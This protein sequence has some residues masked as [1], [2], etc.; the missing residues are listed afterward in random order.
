MGRSYCDHCKKKIAAYDLIPVFS[1]LYL[2]GS[3]RFCG[4]RIN[5]RYPLVEL[6]TGALFIFTFLYA[7]TD[8]LML[9]ILYFGLISTLIVIFFADLKFQII[10][11]RMQLAFLG[12]A[13]AILWLQGDLTPQLA[14]VKFLEGFLIASPLAFIYLYT[15]GKGMGFGD[16]KFALIMGGFLGLKAGFIA[17][18]LAFIIGSILGLILIAL[19]QKKFKSKV[20]FGPFLVAGTVLSIFFFEQIFNFLQ[21]YLG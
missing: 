11:D 21:F 15:K 10:P 12:F 4:K 3:C 18:Y 14:V 16:I 7:P 17:L 20:A 2:R 9:K 1:Y 5:P 8:S 13:A 19:K 6:L